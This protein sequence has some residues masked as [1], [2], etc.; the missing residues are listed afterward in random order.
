MMSLVNQM[1]LMNKL[2][3]EGGGRGM[4]KAMRDRK[5]MTIK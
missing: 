2:E 4:G 3:R 5:R 1:L